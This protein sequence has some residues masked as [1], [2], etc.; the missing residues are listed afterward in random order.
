MWKNPNMDM[1]RMD[2]DG[3]GGVDMCQRVV[4]TCAYRCEKRG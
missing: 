1:N 3:H 4:G 2:S